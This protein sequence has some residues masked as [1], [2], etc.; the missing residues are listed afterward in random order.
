VGKVDQQQD[1]EALQPKGDEHRILPANVVRDPS[2]TSFRNG[3]TVHEP[4][5]AEIRAL[6]AKQRLPAI[7]TLRGFVDA[8]DLMAYGADR[9]ASGRRCAR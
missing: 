7:C 4:H 3:P 9:I 1:P 6:L 8:G 5:R 2:R